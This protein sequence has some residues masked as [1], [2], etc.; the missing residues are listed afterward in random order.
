[1]NLSM[2]ARYTYGNKAAPKMMALLPN[3]MTSKGCEYNSL[4]MYE[5]FFKDNC[6]DIAFPLLQA[7]KSEPTVDQYQIVDEFIDSM[8]LM[9]GNQS[10]DIDDRL[11]GEKSS[12]GYFQKLLDPGLQHA[13]RAIAHRALNPKDTVLKIDRDILEMITS[14]KEEDAKAIVERMK[15]LFPLE[16]VQVANKEKLMERL[17]KWDDKDGAMPPNNNSDNG[18][19]HSDRQI[20]EIGTIDPAE[21]FTELLSRGER[22]D[23][24]AA[25]IQKVVNDIV[26]KS[27]DLMAEKVIKAIFVYREVAKQ[28]SPFKFNEWIK[29]F[30]ETLEQHEKTQLWTKLIVDEK[31]GLITANESELSAV[32]EADARKFLCIEQSLNVA[33]NAGVDNEELDEM[34]DEM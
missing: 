34:F 14:P 5:L 8:D 27:V 22:F 7:K 31:L 16:M 25:Q 24:L 17:R 21:D 33:T 28:K 15:T 13:Y 1:M 12:T 4:L 23:S 18:T 10:K 11:A 29:H 2:I 9:R 6:V 3:T 26:L 19:F 20:V 30:K 32:T